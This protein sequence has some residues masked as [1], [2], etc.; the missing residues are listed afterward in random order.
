[1]MEA[2]LRDIIDLFVCSSFKTSDW[3]FCVRV[4]ALLQAG[5]VGRQ[6]LCW[7]P[8]KWHFGRIF[9]LR[10]FCFSWEMSFIVFC[11]MILFL[12]FG[13]CSVFLEGWFK[14]PVYF[15]QSLWVAFNCSVHRISADTPVQTHVSL[16]ASVH[17]AFLRAKFTGFCSTWQH[18]VTQSKLALLTAQ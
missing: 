5:R 13:C 15:E 18:P 1:M 8:S 11:F 3:D 14:A 10:L 2:L 7:G 12:A 4:R 9:S 6:Q 16:L 17:L